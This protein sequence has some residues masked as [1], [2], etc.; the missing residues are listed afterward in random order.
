MGSGLASVRAFAAGA[1]LTGAFESRLG[2][3]SNPLKTFMADETG[4][5][6]PFGGAED[7]STSSITNSAEEVPAETQR[8][9]PL[10]RA[11][12]DAELADINTTGE[13]RNPR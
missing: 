13:V 12:Q 11:V 7:V 1:E 3:G 2:S 4:S 8:T 6:R 9:V 5:W 10:W